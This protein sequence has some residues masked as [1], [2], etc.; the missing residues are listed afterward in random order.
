VADSFKQALTDAENQLEEL[1]AAR[2]EIDQKIHRV[3]QLIKHLAAIS[4]VDADEALGPLIAYENRGLSSAVKSV[5]RQSRKWHTAAE[6]R[7][8]LMSVDYDLS[9]YANASA[10]INTVLNRLHK[11]DILQKDSQN[12]PAKYRWK[13]DVR[14]KIAKAW[15]ET[16]T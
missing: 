16:K 1:V 14:E 2:A 4:G 7:H 12:V 11:Q 10:V 13:S 9:D 8:L 3:K 5:L 6:V 15:K